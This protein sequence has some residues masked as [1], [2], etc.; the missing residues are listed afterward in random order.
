VA[1]Q[2]YGFELALC[3]SL[4]REREAVV[5]RQLGTSLSGRRVIDAVVVEPGP[6]FDERAAITAE[7]IP[8]PAIESDVGPGTARYWKDAFDIAPE[9]AEGVLDRAVDLGFFERERRG[10][11]TY[12]RQ[13]TRY[14]ED[15][16]AR[17]VG[18]ENKP[19]L[20]RPG[21]LETQLRK[22][23]SLGLLDAVVLATESYVTGAH[24]N[25]IPEAVGV[26]R[27]DPDTGA[28]EVI[29][30]PTPL[31]SDETG[32]DVLERRT[33]RTEIR[34]VDAAAKA[35]QRRRVAERA[36]GK[37]WRTYAFPDCAEVEAVD[38]HGVGG[39]PYCAWKGR[40]VHPASECGPECGGYD[41]AD[42]PGVDLDA[43]RASGQPWRADPE[44][45]KRRQSG[46]DRWS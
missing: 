11:R 2:E 6:G 33:A 21:D 35:R 40:L 23:V 28:R 38:R 9:R 42:P 12:V 3:A 4:E 16:F 43:E 18:V 24:L 5:S 7:T 29:R 27:F 32:I 39:L 30:E 46:L 31:A 15:W 36:Y 17:I 1:V 14:P 13:T 37:G 19:D 20:G 44:G 45:R 10:G 25:R 41:P 34:P 26:W 22:D 8:A